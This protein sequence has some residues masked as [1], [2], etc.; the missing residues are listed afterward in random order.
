MVNI[1]FKLKELFSILESEVQ[2]KWCTKREDLISEIKELERKSFG[3][4]VCIG[5]TISGMYP[6][7]EFVVVNNFDE[8]TYLIKYLFLPTTISY[9]CTSVGGIEAL[10]YAKWLTLHCIEYNKTLPFWTIHNSNSNENIPVA[11][12]FRRCAKFNLPPKKK[13]M[14]SILNLIGF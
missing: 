2:P 5:K 9:S 3:V 14:F 1:Q 7:S 4:N 12:Y 6:F 11:D 8:F 10:D 13:S